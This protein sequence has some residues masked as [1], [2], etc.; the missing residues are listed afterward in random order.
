MNEYPSIVLTFIAGLLS[1]FSPCVFPLIPSYLSILGGACGI[2]VNSEIKNKKRF[3]LF[4][5]S[6]C[7]I[8]GF[9]VV[10]IIFITI[11]SS[12]IFMMSGINKY[13]QVIAGIIV[14]ILGLNFIFDF[15]KI[16]NY[17]KRFNLKEK[18]K[19][20]I[21]SFMAGAAFGTGWTP[22]IGPILSGVLFLASQSGTVGV[23]IIYLLIYSLRLGIPFL[24]MALFFDKYLIPAKWIKNKMPII[25]NISAIVLIIMGIFIL[26]GR[27]S[28][29]NI[30]IQR[31]QIQFID[32]AQDKLFFKIIAGWLLF[33]NW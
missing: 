7:F 12:A 13:I 6:V 29:L 22:C 23:G 25:K 21:G 2:A 3:I 32:W 19:G 4:Y 15:L 5:N 33:I 14:I 24:F 11:F 30:L 1:F 8:L 28:I 31:W 17:E 26:T 20:L 10:F 9:T 16:L 27:Y 18:P